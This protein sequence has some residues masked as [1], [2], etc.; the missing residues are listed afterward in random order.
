MSDEPTFTRGL[1]CDILPP[2]TN[3]FLEVLW[4]RQALKNGRPCRMSF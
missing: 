3:F 4:I 2:V 1:K